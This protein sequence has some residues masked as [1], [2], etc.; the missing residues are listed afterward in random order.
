M[1]R[2][3][4]TERYANAAMPRALQGAGLPHAHLK[5]GEGIVTSTDMLITTVLGSCVS[6]TFFH[7]P[8]GLSGIFHAMLPTHTMRNGPADMPCKFVDS[9]IELIERQF[10]RRGV[11]L[12]DVDVKLFGGAFSMNHGSKEPVR[13][14][15]DVGSKN[16]A[17]AR[18]CMAERGLK[19]LRENVK[20][21]RGRKLIMDTRT[22]EIWMKLLSKSTEV[23]HI[24][25]ANR[26]DDSSSQL[27]DTL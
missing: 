17:M 11:L 19:I 27:L 16:V 1:G 7:Q 5:I 26:S 9:A 15:V 18:Q 12:A 23:P 6:V 13:G 24:D 2:P 14:I 3:F 8:S 25:L 10:S 20:G 4:L 21:A 22:G